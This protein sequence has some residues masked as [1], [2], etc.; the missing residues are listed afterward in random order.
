MSIQILYCHI[1][2]RSQIPSSH[3]AS[4]SPT[5]TYGYALSGRL[6]TMHRAG[7]LVSDY[8][9]DDNGN[10]TSHRT[11]HRIGPASPLRGQSWPCLGALPATGDITI[12]GGYDA[13]DRMTAYGSCSY[14][15]T[16]NGELTRLVDSATASTTEYEYDEFGNLRRVVLPDTRVITYHIDGLNRR[17]GK[18]IDGV[19]QWGLLY[20]NQLEPVAELDAAGNVVSSFIYADRP[21]VPS[22]MLKG[23][24]TY[25]ILADHLGSVRLVVNIVTGAIAQRMSYDEYGNV[26][27][28][29]NPGFQ[30]FGYAGGIY[31]R[32]TGLV[33][34]GARDYDAVAGRWTARDPIHFRGGQSNLYSYVRADPLNL[35]DPTG[36]AALGVC[37]AQEYLNE[38][39]N[40]D[41]AW[42]QAYQDRLKHG[43]HL[44]ELRNAEHYLRAYNKVS[45]NSYNWGPM[46]VNTTGYHTMKFWVNV[47]D[48][49]LDF[50]SPFEHTNPTHAEL[51]SGYQGA[52]DALFGRG[53]LDCGCGR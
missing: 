18:S 37:L 33:R 22:L 44:E 24:Q 43:M 16:R 32:D 53:D 40:P 29:S 30:P 1:R 17:V 19:R 34:F 3:R 49:W 14:E 12:S 7:A 20:A 36:L 52:N 11:S 23:G 25:R 35:I 42:E 15:Y 13:Q 41:A 2:R 27:E 45:E 28:D 31:D 47:S 21:H 5:D 9:F 26:V 10:R 38:H 6:D 50:G 46:L 48:Y 8:D 39:A 51:L 4:A